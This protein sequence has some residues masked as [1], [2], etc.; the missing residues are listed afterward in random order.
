MNDD[1]LIGIW[2]TVEPSAGS[3]RRMQA[4]VFD[5]LDASDTSLVAEWIGL[6]RSAPVPTFGLAAVSAVAIPLGPLVWIATV[7]R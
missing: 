4:R 6:F 5:R 7:L 2:T 1:E 3:R